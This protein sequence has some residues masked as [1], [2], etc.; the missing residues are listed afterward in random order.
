MLLGGRL[1]RYF[2]MAAEGGLQIQ[3]LFRLI[4]YNLPFFL[5]LILPLSFFIALMLCFGRLYADS[6]MAAINSSGISRSALGRLLIPLVV[7]LM[8]FEAYLSLM[9]KPWGVRQSEAIW[10]SQSAVAFFDLIRPKQFISH[11]DYH[12]YVGEMGENRAYLSDVILIQTNI[13]PSNNQN[14]HWQSTPKDTIIIAKKA[15]QTPNNHQSILLDLYEGRRYVFNPITAAYNEASFERYQVSFERPAPALS[16]QKIET[17]ATMQ[18][19]DHLWQNQAQAYPKAVLWAELGYRM[20]LPWLMVFA[21][22]LALPLSQVN[23]RQGRWGR[24]IP[25]ILMFV[26]MVLTIISLK[27]TIEKQKIQAWAYPVALFGIFLLT[28]Y[29]NYHTRLYNRYRLHKATQ[30]SQ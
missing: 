10:Q 16:E 7:V 29:L 1:I 12:L 6:E 21:P 15:T 11:G 5:E 20:S 25:A 30:S 22:M 17:V 13:N 26:M 18:I 9:G 3:V 19:I 4:G 27:N 14:H 8:A 28:L 24:L 2:G 23:P